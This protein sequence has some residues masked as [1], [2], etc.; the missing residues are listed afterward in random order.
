[1]QTR[2]PTGAHHRALQQSYLIATFLGAR[3]LS[4]LEIHNRLEISG[5]SIGH[6]HD[7]VGK[8]G[9]SVILCPQG[10][11]GAAEVRGTA[12]GTRQ[13]DALVNPG[14]IASRVHG[15][16]F[17]GGSG[18]GLAAA[19]GVVSFLEAMGSGF[20]AGIRQVPLVPTAIL[21]DLAFG[22]SQVAP[23]AEMASQAASMAIA[24][25][26][27][28]GSIGAGTGATVGKAKGLTCAMKGGVGFT[29]SQLPGDPSTAARVAVL[30]AVNALGDIV[31]PSTGQLIAGCR[32]SAEG[33]EWARARRLLLDPPVEH[34]WDG[35]TTLI[36]VMTDAELSR[37]DLAKVCTMAFAG[38]S[39][40]VDPALT[41][42]DGDLVVA[43][44][45]GGRS[46]HAHQV[47]VAAQA[48][49]AEAIVA[50]VI[51]ADGFGLLPSAKEGEPRS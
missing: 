16:V 14:H 18:F 49:V 15:L 3:P 9:V 20:N 45:T 46:A 32:V 47:G 13:F 36:A 34:A 35:N 5:L 11:V 28:M 41:Q 40:A 29:A 17:A 30:A 4:D 38:V 42:Y 2:I 39:R 51:H 44:S 1:M 24:G 33:T 21:F 22:D 27:P 26:Q 43:L 19:D 31:S 6:Q 50:A 48:L 12:T 23:T 25:V 7:G 8:T 37:N 10:A